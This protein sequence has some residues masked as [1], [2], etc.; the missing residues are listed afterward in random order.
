MVANFWCD[1]R[2]EDMAEGVEDG[3][4]K[5]VAVAGV[6]PTIAMNGDM[7]DGEQAVVGPRRRGRR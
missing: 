2:G 1:G 7:N 6:M 4:P 5:G 3:A